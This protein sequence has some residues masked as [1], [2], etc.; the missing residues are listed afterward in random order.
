MAKEKNRELIDDIV[1]KMKAHELPYLEGAWEK[2]ASHNMSFVSKKQS[3]WKYWTAA[4]AVLCIASVS[5]LYLKHSDIKEFPNVANLQVE[6]EIDQDKLNPETQRIDVPALTFDNPIANH[7]AGTELGNHDQH[8]SVTKGYDEKSIVSI[9]DVLQV[10]TNIFTDDNERKE[11]IGLQSKVDN[12]SL[13]IKKDEVKNN[14]LANNNTARKEK[15][16]TRSVAEK[17]ERLGSLY[18]SNSEKYDFASG[19]KKWEIGAFVAPSST[20]D[21]MSLGGGISLAYQIT[22]KISIRSGVS[23]QQYGVGANRENNLGAV[24]SASVAYN[25]AVSNNPIMKSD[26][27]LLLAKQTVDKELSAVNNKLLTIDI[28]V[29]VRYHLNKSL[30]TSVGVSYVGVLDQTQENYFVD[31]INEK[32]ATNNGDALT[33]PQNMKQSFKGNAVS[34]NGFNGFV[35]FSIGKKME[36]GKKLKIAVEPFIK[37]PVGGLKSTDL[38]YTNGGLKIVTSF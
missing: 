34:T 11:S 12:E 30:Y 32:T 16:T 17:L 6:K 38:N 14:N 7:T 20:V 4:A 37:L 19:L 10:A 3:N 35:N 29:D 9:D 13:E 27:S 25:N 18:P 24:Q 23:M 1:D 33:S 36:V 5:F 8:G 22:D 15:E 26:E 21:K 28:P 31:G 2:F